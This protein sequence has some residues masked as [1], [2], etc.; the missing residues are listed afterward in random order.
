MMCCEE[1]NWMKVW[2]IAIALYGRKRKKVSGREGGTRAIFCGVVGEL[3][4]EPFSASW[5][6]NEWLC[7]SFALP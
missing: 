7:E 5:V 4:S 1:K 6:L 3:E 2:Y